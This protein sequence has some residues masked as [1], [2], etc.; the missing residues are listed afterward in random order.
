[1]IGTERIQPPGTVMP[2]MA[3]LSIRFGQP[4]I[5]SR[6]E[7]LPEDPAVLR[8]VTD[9]IMRELQKLSGQEYVDSYSP[10]PARRG[11]AAQAG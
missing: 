11:A 6:Y 3:P 8:S 10:G 1:M 5:F 9:E 4:L 2:T 7:G